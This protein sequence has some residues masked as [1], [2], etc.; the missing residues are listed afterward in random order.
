MAVLKQRHWGE[1]CT[2]CVS[3]TGQVVRAHCSY[4]WGTGVLGGYWTP[5]Y[6]YGQRTRSPIQTQVA[7]SGDVD[8]NR[9]TVIMS[10][11][12]QVEPGD[13]LVFLRDDKR[14]MV[15]VVNPTQLHSVDVHQ[16]VQ[17]SELARSARE[18]GPTVDFW[19]DPVWY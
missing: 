12:P 1:K 11:I 18:Y 16:E 2:Y 15:E 13:V 14:Y 5:V 6:G 9:L 19:H 4:C 7:P 10:N 17:V 8:T 3:A